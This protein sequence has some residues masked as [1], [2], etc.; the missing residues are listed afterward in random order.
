MEDEFDT[1]SLSG[2]QRTE[3][4]VAVVDD[5]DSTGENSSKNDKN[6]SLNSKSNPDANVA[7]KSPENADKDQ[8]SKSSKCC[9]LL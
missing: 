8:N 1:G 5:D 6:K 4:K 3:I 9:Y 2:A 7:E